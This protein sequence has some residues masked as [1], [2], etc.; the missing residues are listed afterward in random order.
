MKIDIVGAGPGG[1]LFALLINR[2]FTDYEIRSEY[3]RK[4]AKTPSSEEKK[5]H[6]EDTKDAKVSD[7]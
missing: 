3:S 5:L 6:H 4:G 2:R 1:L 7:K